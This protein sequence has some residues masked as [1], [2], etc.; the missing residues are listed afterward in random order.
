MN[1]SF[2]IAKRYLFAKKKRNAV[3]IISW[4][5]VIS[6]AIGSSALVIVLS[7]FNGLEQLVESLF[8]SFD[9]DIRI[10]ATLGKVFDPSSIPFDEIDQMQGIANYTKVLEEISG[11]RYQEQEVIATLKG[12]EESFLETSKIAE[13]LVDGQAVLTK[14]GLNY[15]L[16]GYGLASE[17]R[18]NNTT[19]TPYLSLFVPKRKVIAG[20]DPSQL[21]YSSKISPSGVFYISPEFDYTYCV[22]PLHFLQDMLDYQNQISAVELKVKNE[23]DIEKISKELGARLGDS[24]MVKNRYEFN[25]LIYKTNKTEKWITFLILIFILI[26]ASFNILSSLSMLIIE[27]KKDLFTLKSLGLNQRAIKNIFFTEGLL[28]NLLGAVTGITIGVVICLMQKHFG[29]VPLEGGIVEYYP[30]E[31]EWLEIIYIVLTVILI[32]LLTSWYP[33]RK[34]TRV[35]ASDA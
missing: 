30:V 3:N 19:S 11:I 7:A 26:I 2:Y 13:N 33:V 5:S 12:V 17:L 15:A 20:I 8:E 22:L 31:I 34:L 28:I 21:V 10:E 4:I 6:V 25:E 16:I 35:D 14:D 9:P 29:L 18:I 1:V 27:K 24:F 32:G 23:K